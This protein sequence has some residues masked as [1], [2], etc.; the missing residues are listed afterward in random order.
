MNL[1]YN[2]YLYGFRKPKNQSMPAK[3]LVIGTRQAD[4]I[5]LKW[6]AKRF[7]VNDVCAILDESSDES[8]VVE[9]DSELDSTISNR[10][11]TSAK[12][13]ISPANQA[14]GLTSD[15]N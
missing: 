5:L 1:F 6:R 15:W 11:S 10:Q 12:L 4:L 14:I 13:M 8:S 3:P 9:S 7:S 2:V